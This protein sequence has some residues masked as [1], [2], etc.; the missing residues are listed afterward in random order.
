[1]TVDGREMQDALAES[2]RRFRGTFEQA[3]VGMAHVGLDG[4][5]L[6]VNGRLCEIVGYPRGELLA[7]TFQDITHPDDLDADLGLLARLRAGEIPTYAME[8]RYVHKGGATVWANLTVSI[9]RDDAGA[10]CYYISVVQDITDRKREQESLR[11]GER[12]FHSL[13]DNIPQLCWMARADGH[14]YWYNLRWYEYTGT[15]PEEMEGW[16]WMKVHDPAVLPSV[17]AGWTDAIADGRPFD[18]TFP[19]RRHDGAFRPFLTRVMPVRGDDGRVAHWFGTNTDIAERLAMEEALRAAKREAEDASHAKDQFLAVLSHELRTPLNPV[20]LSVTSLL[21]RPPAPAEEIVPTL[22]MIKRN[23]EI[24]V[25]L[26]DDLL[27]VMRI[28][29]GRVALHWQV[30]DAHALLVR[31]VQVCRGDAT[32]KGL[33]LSLDLTAARHHVQADPTRLQQAFW[34]LLKNA[35]KFTPS[36]GSVAVRTRDE[37][38]DGPLTIEVIDDGVGIEPGALPHIFDPFRQAETGIV[39]KFGGLGLG[40][41]ITRGIVEAHGGTIA[42]SSP[43]AGRGAR[44]TITL[45]AVPTPLAA[46]SRLDPPTPPPISGPGLDILLVEDDPTTLVVMARLLRSIGHRVTTA[47]TVESALAASH[48]GRHQFLVSDIGLPDG[49]GLDLM[50]Q[51]IA[52]RG[53]IPAIALTGFG[54]DEDVQRSL[55]AGFAAHLTKPIDFSHFQTV[56]RRVAGSVLPST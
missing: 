16:G 18:M 39:R 50:R 20:L 38:P 55:D 54:K 25:R 37:G 13:A 14:I 10:P 32:A 5:W 53:P 22:E 7:R 8:K 45:S 42:A 15:T 23:V 27:D 21:D 3:A 26:I 36:G 33:R 48:S 47:D 1:M 6:A 29:R 19:L 31:A 11:E 28:V 24:E 2:E 49:T 52:L 9:V 51:L 40:L 4:R 46:P 43:G 17:M 30:A 34:N 41:A 56:L 12:Q 44:F 35:I